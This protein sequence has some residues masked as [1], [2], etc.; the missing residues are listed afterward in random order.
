MI[1]FITQSTMTAPDFYYIKS[2]LYLNIVGTLRLKLTSV[3]PSRIS[4]VNM[5]SCKS[6]YCLMLSYSVLYSSLL[7]MSHNPVT[8]VMLLS[9]KCH[10]F[11]SLCVVYCTCSCCSTL[12]SIT[13]LLQPWWERYTSMLCPTYQLK[14]QYWDTI[15]HLSIVKISH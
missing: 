3:T 8:L 2:V 10:H 4:C 12:I 14:T 13:L 5:Y 15:Y 9:I 7:V 11:L 6:S 1:G